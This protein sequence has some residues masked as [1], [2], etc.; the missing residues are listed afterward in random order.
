MDKEYWSK[1]FEYL[2]K[3][4]IVNEEK[5]IEKLAEQYTV[6]LEKIKKEINNWFTRFAVNNQISLRDAKKWL[7]SNELKELQWDIKEYIKHGEENGIDLK[8]KKELENASAKVHISR[9]N[10]LMLQIQER[11]EEL[12]TNQ[13]NSLSDYIIDTY[14]DTYY[15]SAY[16]LQSGFNVAFNIS[17]LDESTITKLILNLTLVKVNPEIFILGGTAGAALATVISNIT[18]FLIVVYIMKKN[19]TINFGLKTIYKPIVATCMMAIC[20]IFTY[21]NLLGI[22][23]RQL[24]II[25]TLIV[26]VVVY[27]LLILKLKVFSESEIQMLPY[28]KNIFKILKILKIYK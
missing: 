2:E 16:A 20:L 26:A 18:S 7:D 14:E 17:A 4:Q 1:R 8:E 19:I 3:L 13:D 25:I 12:Y 27:I 28:G 22:I 11:I 6:A 15:N 23:S 10:A 9:L 5:Y 24:C 21:E